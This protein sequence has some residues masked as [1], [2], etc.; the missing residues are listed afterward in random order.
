MY[1]CTH[2]KAY[3]L[4]AHTA[5][6]QSCICLYI[7]KTFKFNKITDKTQEK[8]HEILLQFLPHQKKFCRAHMSGLSI[9]LI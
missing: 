3:I 2:M 6:S 1:I 4:K 9:F 7:C 5:N 8:K